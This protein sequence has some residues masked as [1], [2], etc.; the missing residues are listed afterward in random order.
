[1]ARRF[2]WHIGDRITLHSINW[3][4]REG[5]AEWPL[6]IVG[7]VNAGPDDDKTF[8]NELYFNYDYLDQA[9]ATGTGTVHQFIVSIDDAAHA[10][11][12]GVAIDRLFANSSSETTTLNEREYVTA[13]IRQVGDVRTFVNYIIGA[14]LFTLLF[15]AGNTMSQSVRDRIPEFGVLKT[16]GFSDRSVWLL[17][18]A[19][20][21]GVVH[22]RLRH[23]PRGRGSCVS[24]CLRFAGSGSDSDACSASTRRASALRCCWRCSAPRFLRRAPGASPSSKRCPGI[25]SS[26]V[27]KTPMNP[28]RQTLAITLINLRS[29]AQRLGTSLVICV[30]IAGVVAVLTVVLA[31]ATG[32]KNT[33]SS[34][35]RDDRAIVL[36]S[37]SQAEALSS[38]SNADLIAI[39]AA[40]GIRRTADGKRAIS[41]E[42]LLSVNL[43]RKAGNIASVSVR[44]LT[45][46]GASVRPEDSS[47]RRPTVR[48]GRARSRRRQVGARTI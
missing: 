34:A 44:G 11:E 2:N 28:L 40:P 41:P 21:V 5:S 45:P 48:H 10:T 31:M 32:L 23:R 4:N 9:R 15:L 1:M 43:N 35:A 25:E 26:D 39:E 33:L 7:F 19:E 42:T 30:G 17:I 14:V 24:A 47:D 12:I 46:I 38:L 37:G 13:Q 3:I 36:R 29:I 16:L 8:A 6:D 20:A 18:A 27:C 22:H